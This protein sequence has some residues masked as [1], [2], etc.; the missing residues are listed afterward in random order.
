MT[1]HHHYHCSASS[2]H[3]ILLLLAAGIPESNQLTPHYHFAQHLVLRNDL[4]GV[5][6]HQCSSRWTFGW[7]CMSRSASSNA[8]FHVGI[9]RVGDRRAQIRIYTCADTVNKKLDYAPRF[10]R[11]GWTHLDIHLRNRTGKRGK[12]LHSG[13]MSMAATAVADIDGACAMHGDVSERRSGC[14]L[15]Q[16]HPCSQAQM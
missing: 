2:L 16:C 7:T 13:R 12:C 5:F 4:M 14:T 3:T 9:A 15:L 8:Q 10:T 6:P 1:D 11:A